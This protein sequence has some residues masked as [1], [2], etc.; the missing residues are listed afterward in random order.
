LNHSEKNG[1]GFSQAQRRL[2]RG[3]GGA[4]SGLV[5]FGVEDSPKIKIE[6]IIKY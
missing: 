2:C 1:L 6:N 5:R 4:I 3:R